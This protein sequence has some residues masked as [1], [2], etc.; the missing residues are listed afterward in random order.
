MIDD[1][2]IEGLSGTLN[3]SGEADRVKGSQGALQAVDLI[4]KI[5]AIRTGP[6]TREIDGF[7]RDFVIYRESDVDQVP[8]LCVRIDDRFICEFGIVSLNK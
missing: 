8:I 3:V 5:I 2:I 4:D 7:V 6:V 1:E